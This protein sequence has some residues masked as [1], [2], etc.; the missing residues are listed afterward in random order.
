VFFVLCGA[1]RLI[2]VR[3]F[4]MNGALNI[5]ITICLTLI[6]TSC[7]SNQAPPQGW[8]PQQDSYNDP[9]DISGVY[10]NVGIDAEGESKS[11]AG[12][13]IFNK[14]N[15]SFYS[16]SF[17]DKKITHVVIKIVTNRGLEVTALA[18]GSVIAGKEYLESRNEFHIENG[19]VMLQKHASAHTEYLE[20]G[21]RRGELSLSMK[22]KNEL[23]VKDTTKI[24]GLL[25]LIPFSENKETWSVFTKENISQ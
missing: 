7:A 2:V 23:V 10:R 15:D 1:R 17:L 5:S 24:I 6:L 18:N 20:N 3:L 4:N 13:L 14:F 22:G 12:L 9:R 25:V 11:L 19:Q 8:L 21:V 16:E